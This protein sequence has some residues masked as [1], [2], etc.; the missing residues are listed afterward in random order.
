MVVQVRIA[1]SAAMRLLAVRVFMTVVVRVCS[2]MVALV[3]VVVCGMRVRHGVFICGERFD[4]GPLY[5]DSK[6]AAHAL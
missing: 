6:G 5:G 2:V 4:Y 3:G 1:M